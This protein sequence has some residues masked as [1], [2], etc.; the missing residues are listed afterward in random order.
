MRDLIRSAKSFDLHHS[1]SPS[2]GLLAFEFTISDIEI[3][4][5]ILWEW[6]EAS[7][8]GGLKIPKFRR[9]DFNPR[10]THQVYSKVI[11][12]KKTLF[13]VRGDKECLPNSAMG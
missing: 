2:S 12:L 4:P 10:L 9:M 8:S 11:Q 5:D 13:L 7:F 6:F 3:L 1:H